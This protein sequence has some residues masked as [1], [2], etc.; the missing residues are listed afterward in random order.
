MG[1]GVTGALI[2]I[3]PIKPF[4]EA[5]ARLQGVLHDA[6]RSALSRS[7]FV[8]TLKVLTRARGIT[9]VAVVSR[10]RDVLKLAR[11]AGAWAIWERQQGL[12]EA[13][14]Q[15]TRVALAN[16]AQ[17]VLIVPA[18]LPWLQARDVEQMIELG[19]NAPCVVLAPAQRDEGTNA[20]LVNPAGLIRYAFGE[21]SFAEHIRRAEQAGA[22]VELYRSESVAFDL[23]LPEDF[24][25]IQ[26]DKRMV[27]L[28]FE[29]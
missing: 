21:K 15:G 23:D 24:R 8:R 7:L 19:K 1:D 14:E 3:V 6:E 20:A 22:R 27:N 28:K 12:N 4:A 25:Q 10:D 5:K 17:A 11:A 2:T 29:I 9:R 18:D 13:L 16:G 26:T